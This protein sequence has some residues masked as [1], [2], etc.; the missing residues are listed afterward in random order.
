MNKKQFIYL[1]LFSILLPSLT[2]CGE[3]KEE[4]MAYSNELHM[5]FQK[6]VWDNMV[7]DIMPPLSFQK[8]YS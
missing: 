2:G 5:D 3:Q 1:G 4:V 7:I 6:E 8:K